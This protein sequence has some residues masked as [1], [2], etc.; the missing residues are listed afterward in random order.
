[1]NQL[2]AAVKGK[3]SARSL[4]SIVGYVPL[5]TLKRRL[6]GFFQI[7]KFLVVKRMD[8]G[9]SRIPGQITN[10]EVAESCSRKQSMLDKFSLQTPALTTTL[11]KNKKQLELL[12]TNTNV[13]WE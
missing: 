4:L 13:D 6:K 2:L 11:E 10:P 9:Y 1:M 12:P 3:L 8:S 5:T 7:S